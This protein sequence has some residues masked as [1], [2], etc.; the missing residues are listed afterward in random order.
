MC[1]NRSRTVGQETGTLP[2]RRLL[3]SEEM[4]FMVP[5]AQTHGKLAV[6]STI[7]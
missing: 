1:G 5:I 4:R 3:Q 2:T 6:R 7:I